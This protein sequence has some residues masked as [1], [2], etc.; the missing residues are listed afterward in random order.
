MTSYRFG[1]NNPVR[2]FDPT[3]LWEEIAGGFSTNDRQEIG[4]FH[5]ML[6]TERALKGKVPALDQLNHF[7]EG[8]RSGGLGQ[9]SDGSQRW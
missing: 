4:R 1:F 8:E 6:E 7:V 9:L 2:Y 5:Q 3:G